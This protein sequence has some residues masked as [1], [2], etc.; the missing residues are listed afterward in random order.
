MTIT[1]FDTNCYCIYGV[2]PQYLAPEPGIYLGDLQAIT[3]ADMET[4]N[5]HC[6]NEVLPLQKDEHLRSETDSQ[7]NTHNFKLPELKL[8]V[9]DGDKIQWGSFW[10]YFKEIVD[11]NEQLTDVEKFCYLKCMLKGDAEHV[12]TELPLSRENYQVAK[13][14]L[15]DRFENTRAVLHN[16]FTQI[17]CQSPAQNNTKSLRL[18]YDKLESHLRCLEALQQDTSHDI[19]V[20]IISSKIPKDVFLQLELQKGANNEWSVSLLRECFKNYIVAAEQADLLA[21][22]TETEDLREKCEVYNRASPPQRKRINA[23]LFIKCHYCSCNHWSDQCTDYKTV[24]DR[25]NKLK[26]CCFLCLKKGHIASK[27]LYNKTCFHCGRRNHHHRSLCPN[28]VFVNET[29]LPHRNNLNT[30]DR[31]KSKHEKETTQNH[32]NQTMEIISEAEH[33]GTTTIIA[34]VTSDVST[35]HSKINKDDTKQIVKGKKEIKE[36]NIMKGTSLP[37]HQ[38]LTETEQENKV[39]E[40]RFSNIGTSPIN[41]QNLSE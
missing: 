12:I 17:L 27:C 1:I 32:A 34:N 11:K 9:F 28:I 23:Q 4:N 22:G 24:D 39:L 31:L 38:T 2:S 41:K 26:D 14:L 29:G 35:K 6:F 40:T 20:S 3:T 25:K 16:H 30:A 5:E 37:N 19:F 10:N 8:P 18:T 33:N 36:A 21:Y 15:K 13:S 7:Q